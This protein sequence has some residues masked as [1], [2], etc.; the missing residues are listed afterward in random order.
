MSGKNLFLD[1]KDLTG[2]WRAH[3]AEA[4][5]RSAP[6][7]GGTSASAFTVKDST[8]GI[9]EIQVSSAGDSFDTVITT[10]ID[11]WC[12]IYQENGTWHFRNSEVA[13]ASENFLELMLMV[14][15]KFGVDYESIEGSL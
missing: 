1:T 9:T 5:R 12:V 4:Y 2:M 7:A 3:I 11:E 6:L 14:A 13:W 8:E 10:P 15:E